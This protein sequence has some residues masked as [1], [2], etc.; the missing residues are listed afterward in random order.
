[1]L[2]TI[3]I[4]VGVFSLLSI[5][6]LR[7]IYTVIL[8]IMLFASGIALGAL[9]G[10]GAIE[11]CEKFALYLVVIVATFGIKRLSPMLKKRIGFAQ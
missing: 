7:K 2:L 8:L 3:H 6:F 9:S 11:T 5:F 1:M 4:L 10:L